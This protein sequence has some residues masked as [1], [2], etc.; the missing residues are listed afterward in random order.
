MFTSS[1]S[2]AGEALLGAPDKKLQACFLAMLWHTELTISSHIS[3]LRENKKRGTQIPKQPLPS[4][5]DTFVRSRE[6]NWC[7]HKRA[8]CS[9]SFHIARQTSRRNETWQLLPL[10]DYSFCTEESAGGFLLSFPSVCLSAG[11]SLPTLPFTLAICLGLLLREIFKACRT[12][13]LKV[14]VLCHSFDEFVTFLA[15]C[16]TSREHTTLL[17]RVYCSK[18]AEESR[19]IQ[20]HLV[21][22]WRDAD[23][24]LYENLEPCQQQF[25]QWVPV[26]I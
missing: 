26:P 13:V 7:C 9:C 4:P 11:F 24:R 20:R 6:S 1:S 19:Y 16:I 10:W 2:S 12:V 25:L 15:K 14:S 5:R 3:F 23:H 18:W 8:H 17:W 22:G 21:L